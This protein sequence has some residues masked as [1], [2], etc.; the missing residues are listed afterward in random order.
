MPFFTKEKP[1]PK[2]M[3]QPT[4]G[5]WKHPKQPAVWDRKIGP[6]STS[7]PAGVLGALSR[8]PEASITGPHSRRYR[9]LAPL[10]VQIGVL[11]PGTVL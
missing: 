3:I 1:S 11:G 6:V 4:L 10:R 2:I 5:S 9:G 7:G 8:P